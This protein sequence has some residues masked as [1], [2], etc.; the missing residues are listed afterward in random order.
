MSTSAYKG[1]QTTIKIGDGASPEVFTTVAEIN[2]FGELGQANDL[3]EV[4]HLLSTAKE[5]IGGLPDGVEI[6]IAANYVPNDTAQVAA[7]AK[8]ASGTTANF[9]YIY[10]SGAAGGSK[11]F[12]FAALVLAWNIGPTTP[13]EAV[14]LNMRLKVSGAITGP[15]T[16]A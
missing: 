11:M 6:P 7:I 16:V 5:Y 12:T 4:T 10:P 8:V 13:N 1:S 2:N 15:S 9:K 14:K 3:I